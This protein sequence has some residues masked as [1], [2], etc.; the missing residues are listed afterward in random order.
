[1][2]LL[3]YGNKVQIRPK[4]THNVTLKLT[5]DTVKDRNGRTSVLY[6]YYFILYRYHLMYQVPKKLT[7]LINQ[8]GKSHCIFCYEIL[9]PCTF[10]KHHIYRKRALGLLFCPK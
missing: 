1:M 5:C 4:C 7:F 8:K 2:T 10:K 3:D 6:R 9:N